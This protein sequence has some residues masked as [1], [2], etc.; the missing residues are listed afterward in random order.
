[1]LPYLN[2]HTHHPRLLPDVESVLSLSVGYDDLVH[3]NHHNVALGIHP[4]FI[5][6]E[7]VDSD[8]I[9]LEEM[10]SLPQVRMIGECGLD[11]LKGAPREVQL[12]V[13][14]RQLVLARSL[15]KPVILHCVKAYDELMAM[16]KRIDPQVPLVIHGFN[17]NEQLGRQLTGHG[18]QL[19]FGKAILNE[20]SGAAALLKETND[21]FLETDDD[22]DLH[23]EAIYAAAANLKNITVEEL[24]ALIFA[25][26]K[27]ANLI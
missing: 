19:S 20:N 23:I 15:K 22:H 8:L 17:K 12:A 27:G 13:F 25:N 24:K 16:Q 6:E 3:L 26:W 2:I 11:H 7:T 4:W 1:M 9:R 18:F 14:E 21:F 5:N 10:A